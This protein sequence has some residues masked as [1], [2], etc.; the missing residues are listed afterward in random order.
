M[1]ERI[2][3]LIS[4][5]GIAS[6]RAAEDLI[7]S[8]RVH[9]NG[10]VA[11]LGQSADL[12][13]DIVTVDGEPIKLVTK[14]VYI[15][16]NKPRGYV[17]T[18]KDDRERPTVMELISDA[19][20]RVYPVGRLDMDSEG[21]L[22]LTNDGEAANKLMHPSF[23][24]LKTYVV[25]VTGKNIGNAVKDLM[26]EITIDGVTVRAKKVEIIREMPN[27]AKL[28]ITIGEGRNRQVRKMCTA[29]GLTVIELKRVSEGFLELGDLQSGKWRHLSAEEIEHLQSEQNT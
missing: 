26:G 17:T 22:I 14:K 19:G 10:E 9:I 15:M 6:R 5:A 8:G 7:R 23:G 18:V 20:E 24:H 16:L 29:A 3:K 1:S 12:N 28:S 13:T 21:L 2:Q 25:K 11:M 27:S 4:S